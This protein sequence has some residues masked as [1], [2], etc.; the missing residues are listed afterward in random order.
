MEHWLTIKKFPKYEIST[1]GNVRNKTTKLILKPSPDRY[2]YLRLTLGMVNNVYIHRL[3]AENF[4]NREEIHT[5]VNHIDGDRTNNHVLNLE[6]C[7]ASE[8]IKWSVHK[9][10]NAHILASERAAIVNSKPVRIVE[11]DLVFNSIVSCAQYLGVRPTSV[12][13]HLKGIR[14]SIKGVHIEYV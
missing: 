6:W 10:T 14:K 2:G 13:R 8:N 1:H 7:T 11:D 3:V 4:Y 12:W 5:Q 9:K